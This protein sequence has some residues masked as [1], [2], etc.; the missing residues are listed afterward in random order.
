MI[1]IG[2]DLKFLMER[3]RRSKKEMAA[4]MGLTEP[5]FYRILQ[6]DHISTKLLVQFSDLL[7]VH[8]AVFFNHYEGK[9]RHILSYELANEDPAS[10]IYQ[11]LFDPQRSQPQT[12]QA[13]EDQEED[14]S[15][16]QLQEL[17]ACQA[18]NALLHQQNEGL[19]AQVEILKDHI[20]SL[21]QIA[22]V[23]KGSHS[24]D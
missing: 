24:K 19:K 12:A 7:E 11:L 8:P 5:S 10:T 1:Q 2:R 18:E 16:L 3:D 20:H 13:G 17:R 21:K 14:G 22:G 23:G 4:E 15:Q 9:G 6:K